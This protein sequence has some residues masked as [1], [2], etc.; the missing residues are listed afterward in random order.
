MP[1]RTQLFAASLALSGLLACGHAPHARDLHKASRELGK[2]VADEDS[3]AVDAALLPGRR[4]LV[5]REELLVDPATRGAWARALENPTSVRPEGLLQIESDRFVDIVWTDEGWRFRG[6]P[7]DAYPQ[8]TPREALGSLVRAS[9]NARWDVMLDLAPRRYRIGLS[10]DEIEAAWT[11]GDYGE[12]LRESRDKL[13][14]HLAD[15]IV[16]DAH[17]ALLDLTGGRFARLER[18]GSRWVVV[19][20]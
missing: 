13:A 4:A 10:V 1:F 17:H 6:D 8:S 16:A 12:A 9:R 5:D 20:F 15:P 14:E 19:D 3:A 7:G 2:A 11:E 18:E